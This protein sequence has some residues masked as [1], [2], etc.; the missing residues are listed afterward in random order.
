LVTINDTDTMA[1]KTATGFVISFTIC[2]KRARYQKK[3]KCNM[4]T[5]KLARFDSGS[6]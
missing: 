1:V 5:V 3:H 2:V 6:S 4:F